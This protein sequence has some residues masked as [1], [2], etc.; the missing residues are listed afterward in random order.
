MGEKILP[1]PA[2]GRNFI[3][4]RRRSGAR[5]YDDRA[6]LDK[7]QDALLC[8]IGPEI[9]KIQAW[10]ETVKRL[11][12]EDTRARIPLKVVLLGLAPLLIQRGLSESLA[13]R[14][15]I[16]Q[17][18]HWSAGE[19]REAF[20]W[21]VERSI[22]YGGY[23][24][25][26]ALAD[27]HERWTRYVRDALI[28]TTLSRDVLLLTRVDKP[29]LLRRL[30]DLGCRYSRQIL[31]YNKMRR[32]RVSYGRRPVSTWISRNGSCPSAGAHH[33]RSAHPPVSFEKPSK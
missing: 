11:W 28:E 8:R 31:S 12:D 21:P 2:A 4:L 26:A 27:D 20:G 30:F 32:F 9:Q 6:V 15:E 25:A 23:P 1:H 10:S 7:D 5:I 17:L 16:L 3:S 24:G 19:M 29:A 14:F 22:F 33:P 13:G 18:G